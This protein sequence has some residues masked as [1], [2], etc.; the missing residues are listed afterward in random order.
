MKD[1]NIHKGEIRWVFH[2]E[3]KEEPPQKGAMTGLG[4]V[5]NISAFAGKGKHDKMKRNVSIT[6]RIF[7]RRSS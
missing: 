4:F 1:R 2:R 3:G 7:H 5:R 6:V